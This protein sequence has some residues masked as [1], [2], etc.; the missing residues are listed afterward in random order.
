MAPVSYDAGKYIQSASGAPGICPSVDKRR[1]SQTF[2]ER[3]K[4][5]PLDI[6]HRPFGKVEL[7]D[8]KPRQLLGHG[9]VP[10]QE[11]ELDR[12]GVV[13][14]PQIDASRLDIARRY[15]RSTGIDPS[16][17]DCLGQEL[18]RQ[19]PLRLRARGRQGTSR[20]ASQ[21]HGSG[22]ARCRLAAQSHDG[23]TGCDV[24][25]HSAKGHSEK[26]HSEKG[27]S[28]KG[29]SVRGHSVRG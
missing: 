24:K 13:T 5:G 25:G 16:G 4:V 6:Q 14:E 18:A 17:V 20:L 29:H 1:Q 26:G 10:G 28:E 22:R 21:G 11:A 19:D 15:G 7:L 3:Y 23:V 9:L 2:N 12:I 27:H 8:C